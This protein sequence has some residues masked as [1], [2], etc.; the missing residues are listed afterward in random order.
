MWPRLRLRRH[1]GRGGNVGGGGGEGNSRRH[2][3]TN[4]RPLCRLNRS[5]GHIEG[6]ACV[7]NEL[8]ATRAKL[9][10]F[11]RS[12]ARIFEGRLCPLEAN[13]DKPRERFLLRVDTLNMGLRLGHVRV[14]APIA[15][16]HRGGGQRRWHHQHVDEEEEDDTS[17]CPAMKIA[18]P[19][20]LLR[21]Y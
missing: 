17:L 20:L 13:L 16:R 4:A 18:P 14:Q 15:V 10:E 21:L 6:T 12:E 11:I 3:S 5:R 2:S 1:N 9:S 19:R 8:D 7:H